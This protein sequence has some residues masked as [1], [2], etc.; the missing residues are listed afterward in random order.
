M[1]DPLARLNIDP[2]ALPAAPT[3]SPPSSLVRDR[4][5]PPHPAPCA[6]CGGVAIASR[7]VHADDGPRWLD[8]CRN[9]LLRAA[10]KKMTP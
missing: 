9:D 3:G 4:L 5:A 7:I 6:T 2:S 1:D 10:G 8:L